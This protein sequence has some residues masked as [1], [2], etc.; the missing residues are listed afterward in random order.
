MQIG[1][2]NK[3]TRGKRARLLL[4]TTVAGFV[5][6]GCSHVMKP[7]PVERE[8]HIIEELQKSTLIQ[9]RLTALELQSGG[10]MGV[11]VVG[12]KGTMLVGYRSDERFAMCS[13][14]KTLLAA[15]ILQK[16]DRRSL[17]LRKRIIY[18]PGELQ[19]YAPVAKR[20]F[21]EKRNRGIMT[22]AE[23]A[24]A[25]VVDSDNSAANLLLGQLGGAEEITRFARSLGD[26][27]TRLDRTEPTL[28]ENSLGDERDTTSPL[29]IAKLNQ[30][31]I[32]GSVLRPASRQRLTNWLIASPT[33][34][35][36]I[37]AGLPT[38]WKAGS[39][40]GSCGNAYNDVAVA[41]DVHG[42]PI[43]LAIYLDRP[44][45]GGP[46]ANR[47]IADVARLVSGNNLDGA[48]DVI[49]Q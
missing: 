12:P 20:H 49:A 38:D 25:S 6:S 39:K 31:I 1:T 47:I 34:S 18:G 42:H 24:E 17:S 43:V 33:G 27:T 15:D 23:L 3:R 11:A 28:N 30:K 40:T 22:V 45:K 19:E 4:L 35:E 48:G 8:A 10:R 21:D 26:M 32:F 13:T 7:S 2:N 41:W 9:D 36:R 37:R 14:F 44:T 16:V 5:V 46:D 29:A